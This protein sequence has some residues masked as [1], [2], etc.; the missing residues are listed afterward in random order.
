MSGGLA[1]KLVRLFGSARLATALLALI[2][3][4]S[5]LASFVPQGDASSDAVT[6]W[7]SANPA[8]AS[9][10]RVAG[11]HHAFS[12][13]PFVFCVTVLALF[14]TMCAWQRTRVAAKRTHAMRGAALDPQTLA[15][16][17]DVRIACD[18]ELNHSE[19]LAKAAEALD[20]IG[21]R[22][23]PRG[24]V[25]SAVSPRWT[26]WGSPVFHWA[27]VAIIIVIPLGALAR[28][29]GQMGIAVGDVKVDQPASYGLLSA[30]PWR[31]W[32]SVER[33]IR[34]D[35]FDVNYT[36]G[37]VHRGATP[38][39]S[40]LNGAGEVLASQRVYPNATLKLRSLT[41]YPL[42]YGLA[43]DI[44]VADASGAEIWRSREL[45]DFSGKAEGG[46][47][48]VSPLVLE[49]QGGGGD[50]H[51]L[52]SVPLDRTEGGYLG[53]LPDDLRARI[54]VTSADGDPVLD[55]YLRPGEALALPS[56]AT[57]R[58]DGLGY[59]A[60]L[61]LVDDPSIPYLYAAAFIAMLGLGVAT[62]ARQMI[63][64]AWKEDAPDGIHLVLRMRLW[65]IL[66]TNRRE[67][68]TRLRETVGSE[69]KGG[70][71]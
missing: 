21:I 47:A 13:L 17:S 53:R 20:G 5:A 41:I 19:I 46:T 3:L 4:W 67:I 37:G 68:E 31:N 55:E 56:G 28:S 63:V 50:L 9:L 26:A 6:A 62:F 14:T 36:T 66:T 22:V 43:A 70:E 39:V 12:A 71:S 11:L 65:R 32:G 33:T 29:S 58:L 54:K 30:G 61:Q 38:T 8:V 34:V 69:E 27:L 10:A 52:I 35:A 2:A 1:R 23:R 48:P 44:S 16:D 57:L 25:L 24:G 7:A 42:D 45:L 49:N 15:A 18:P 64:L 51:V 40:V 60:R 59:Y